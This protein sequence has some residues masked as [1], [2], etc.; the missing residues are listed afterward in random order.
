M[1][2]L[3]ILSAAFGLAA[4]QAGAACDFH[5]TTASK[6]DTTKVASVSADET[7]N[8]STPAAPPAQSPV[9]VE[10]DRAAPVQS[11]SE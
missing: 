10:Q 9:I 7:R 8:R 5:K 4:S 11:E 2:R 1:M 6:V 3:L